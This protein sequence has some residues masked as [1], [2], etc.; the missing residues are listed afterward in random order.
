M[1]DLPVTI[2]VEGSVD[3]LTIDS[4]E[5]IA[6]ATPLCEAPTTTPCY[7]CRTLAFRLLLL[8]DIR[9]SQIR[10]TE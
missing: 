2:R 4:P 3:D 1:I 5:V 10:D 7:Q 9:V 8:G 6:L